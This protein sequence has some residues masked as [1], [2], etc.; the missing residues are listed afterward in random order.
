MKSHTK[1]VISVSD[2]RMQHFLR[3]ASAP[4]GKELIAVVRMQMWSF[5]ICIFVILLGFVCFF[6]SDNLVSWILVFLVLLD[7]SLIVTATSMWL[8]M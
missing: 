4:P 1:A 7:G 6:F 5:L 8:F 2:P 3:P